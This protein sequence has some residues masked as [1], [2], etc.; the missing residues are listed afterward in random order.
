MKSLTTDVFMSYTNAQPD[1]QF[2]REITRDKVNETATKLAREQRERISA[3][4]DQA[5]AEGA[6]G[7]K[8]TWSAPKIEVLK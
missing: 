4:V 7:L 8:I 6:R 1:L 3:A 2:T 5:A